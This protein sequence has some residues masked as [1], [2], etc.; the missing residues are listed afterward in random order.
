LELNPGVV[1]DRLTGLGWKSAAFDDKIKQTTLDARK[2]TVPASH[3]FQDDRTNS[4]IDG[5][6]AEDP[7]SIASSEKPRQA[8]P[9]VSP[10]EVVPN[11]PKPTDEREKKR[12]MEEELSSVDHQRMLRDEYAKR[13][14][15]EKEKEQDRPAP[16]QPPKKPPQIP[17][18]ALDKEG[19]E[20]EK[21]PQD[22]KSMTEYAKH[23]REKKEQEMKLEE[24]R[25]IAEDPDYV[26]KKPLSP[27]HLPKKE[28]EDD[29]KPDEKK[30]PQNDKTPPSTK[31]LFD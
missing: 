10:N 29:R 19:V 13:I 31:T 5:V 22:F 9:K 28:K 14:Q 21:K 25:K 1:S 27:Q 26:P 3:L 18:P 12:W 8:T 7:P 15:K 30:S 24:E 16:K 2:S 17:K 20:R 4:Q 11:R 23:V 6:G